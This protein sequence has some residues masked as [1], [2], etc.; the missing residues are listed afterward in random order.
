MQF[1]CYMGIKKLDEWFTDTLNN[2]PSENAD[3]DYAKRVRDL[4][5]HFGKQPDKNGSPDKMVPFERKSKDT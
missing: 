4:T 5:R 1:L 2:L 3:A